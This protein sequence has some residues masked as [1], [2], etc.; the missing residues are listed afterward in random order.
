MRR[1]LAK[2]PIMGRL[3]NIHPF[4]AKSNVEFSLSG[5]PRMKIW[6]AEIQKSFNRRALR[7]FDALNI[8]KRR[9]KLHITGHNQK[10]RIVA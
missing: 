4:L 9:P 3:Q 8:V 5:N 7:H 10:M 6:S 2:V 1:S